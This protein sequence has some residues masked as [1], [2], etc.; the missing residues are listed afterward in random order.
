MHI[1]TKKAWSHTAG[2]CQ[3]LAQPV[4]SFWGSVQPLAASVSHEISRRK[5]LSA[6]FG[7][8]LTVICHCIVSIYY[9][10]YIMTAIL[11]LYFE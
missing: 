2:C 3:Q 5:I 7:C 11:P 6:H 8:L 9:I 1:N 4:G 10:Y